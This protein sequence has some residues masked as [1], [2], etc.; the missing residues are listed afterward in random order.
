MEMPYEE[1]VPDTTPLLVAEHLRRRYPDGAG[2]LL[3]GIS[4]TLHGGSRLALAGPSGSGKT[5]L[6]RSL[7]LLD[8]VDHGRVLWRGE[9]VAH[10]RVPAFRSQVIYLHQRPAL[11]GDSVRQVLRVPY[12]LAIHQGQAYDESRILAW[13]TKLGRSDGLLNRPPAELSGGERQIVALLRAIQLEPVVLLLDEP[14]AALDPE[15]VDSIERLVRQ[16]F[17][18]APGRRAF[19]WVSHDQQ[20]A[21]R[22]TNETIRLAEG[23]QVELQT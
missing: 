9:P 6:L 22:M 12:R 13:L 11:W 1:S 5:L 21:L 3:D 8:P 15:A 19:C 18:D 17:D 14:T 7:A 20:Q 23:R 10:T 4:M 2:W 16:W